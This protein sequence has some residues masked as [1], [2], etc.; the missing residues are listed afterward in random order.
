MNDFENIELAD[1]PRVTAPDGAAVRI[2]CATQGGSGAY[3]TLAPGQISM[4]VR[5]RSVE[6]IWFVVAGRGRMWRN[7]GDLEEVVE[8]KPDLCLSIPVGTQFQ[9]R[10]DGDEPLQAYAVTMPPWP[11]EDEAVPV[12]GP[13]VAG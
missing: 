12:A 7:S 8:L 5:H 1:A 2:L 11:G 13:W 3:F 4:A 10:N 9:F 6:E